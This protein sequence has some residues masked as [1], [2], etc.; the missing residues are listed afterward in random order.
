MY[1][2]GTGRFISKDIF[3]G[4]VN[5]PNTFNGYVYGANNPVRYTDPM[6]LD[7]EDEAAQA[8]VD[9]PP[10]DGS[11]PPPDTSAFTA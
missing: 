2:A 6:G 7:P 9:P 1:S 11:D 10:D 8:A 3:Q 4:D 5:R